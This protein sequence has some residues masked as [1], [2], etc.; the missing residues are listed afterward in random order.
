MKLQTALNGGYK[1][2]RMIAAIESKVTCVDSL[3]GL[4]ISLDEPEL[5]LNNEQAIKYVFKDTE[6]FRDE[7]GINES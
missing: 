2:D 1:N 4:A 6:Y 7:L 3:K 5:D